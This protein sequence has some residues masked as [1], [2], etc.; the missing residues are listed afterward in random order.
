VLLLPLG[1][2]LLEGA[3]VEAAGVGTDDGGV[4]PEACGVV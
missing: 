4:E 1:A 2:V 3:G